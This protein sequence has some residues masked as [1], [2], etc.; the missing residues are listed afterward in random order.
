MN[1][2]H[3]IVWPFAFT[4][5]ARGRKDG[6]RSSPHAGSGVAMLVYG[7]PS[8]GAAPAEGLLTHFEATIIANSERQCEAR[9]GRWERLSNHIESEAARI[10][11]RIAEGAK[12]Y[13]LLTR[14]HDAQGEQEQV[15]RGLAP[16]MYLTGMLCLCA[17]EVSVNLPAFNG[18]FREPDSWSTF[19]KFGWQLYLAALLPSVLIPTFGHFAG[20]ALKHKRGGNFRAPDATIFWGAL[21]GAAGIILAVAQL[22]V[23]DLGHLSKGAPPD[24]TVLLGM[25][26]L[27]V[28]VLLVSVVTSYWSHDEDEDRERRSKQRDQL[29][30]Q[31]RRLRRRWAKLVARFDAQRGVAIT[32]LGARRQHAIALVMEYRD[33]FLQHYQGSALAVFAERVGER[34]FKPRDLPHEVGPTPRPIEELADE[35]RRQQIA[36]APPGERPILRTNGTGK[37]PPLA[38]RPN[39]LEVEGDS[40]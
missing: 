38:D 29:L 27:N 9:L 14:A 2:L 24:L 17:C 12:R 39:S 33:A 11:H 4:A 3:R 13:E 28:G 31:D 40:F 35:L 34:F 5:A 22:R 21:T 19:I 6:R 7:E 10:R 36:A 15:H 1:I 18:W 23:A 32:D 37:A 16:W 8:I 26:A 20:A 30:R 25:V